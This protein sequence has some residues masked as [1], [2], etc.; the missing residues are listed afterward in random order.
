LPT[1]GAAFSAQNRHIL[2]TL[3][4]I[5]PVI[6]FK[7]S[8]G[9][10]T[11]GTLVTLQRR[12]LVMEIYNPYSIVQLSEVLEELQVRAGSERSIY[13]G[14]AVVVSLLNTGLMAI[15]SVTLI[16]EWNELNGLQ[17]DLKLIGQESTNFIA[18]WDER[19]K[20]RNDYQTVVN[21]TRSYLTEVSR[22]V[23]QAELTGTFPRDELGRI[24]EDVFYDFATPIMVRGKEYLDLLENEAMRLLPEESAT[25]RAYAQNTLHPLLLRAP[26]VYRT[27]AKPLGYAGDYEMVNQIL[28]DPRQGPS[29]YFQIINSVFLL[30]SVA[31][32]HRNR[33]EILINY[34]KALSLT[35]KKIKI[36]NIACGPAA[37]I[38]KAIMSGVLGNNIEVTL[39]DFSIETLNYTQSKIEDACKE[40]NNKNIF[41]YKHQS[42]HELLKRATKDKAIEEEDKYD[43]VYCAGLFDYLTDKVCS[44]L[45]DYF[46]S[47]AKKDSKILVTNVHKNNKEKNI[48]EHILEW[49]LIYRDEKELEAVLPVNRSD[50]KIY[51]DETG[52]NVFAEF[53]NRANEKH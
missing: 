20:L 31:Q 29:A 26:F 30:N 38:Q 15:V 14:K 50:T 42:V 37:E 28:S 46:A 3:R 1:L 32:A 49:H 25:H 45:L 11:R 48:M 33:I 18:R 27:F 41:L 36:L 21:E 10:A 5:D 9:E 34:L 24:R 8:Q 51:V 40:K 12:S 6:T 13:K 2:A 17:H 44:R 47:V 35:N 4:P 22:W 43:F 16:D 23:D 53:T 19:I 7:N 39:L 52:I